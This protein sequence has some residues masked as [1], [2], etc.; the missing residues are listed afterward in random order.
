[1]TLA[2]KFTR[3]KTG[4]G[5]N[6]EKFRFEDTFGMPKEEQ[7]HITRPSR[8]NTRIL[9][10]LEFALHLTEEKGGQYDKILEE[11]LDYLLNR[12]EEEGVLTDQVCR[13]A[14]EILSPMEEEAKSYDLILAAHAHIDMNWMWS[15]TE[16][17]SIVLATFRSILNVAVFCVSWCEWYMRYC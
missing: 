4:V 10:E 8:A 9:S 2:E 17:V 3:L 15:F 5:G 13:E 16:T 6:R 7:A 1:M 12:Q 14:E 11:A